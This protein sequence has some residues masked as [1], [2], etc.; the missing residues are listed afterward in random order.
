MMA[1]TQRQ[2]VKM[3]VYVIA[4]IEVLDP[5]L[6][7]EYRQKVPATIAAHGGR[8]VARGGPTEVLEGSWTPKRCVVLE[9][10]DMERFKTW[11]SSP[12]Y[13][14]LRALRQRASNSS[15]VVTQGL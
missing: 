6:F 11:W 5:V 2:G 7:E 13:A 8:Y 10:P 9:F 4:D 15:L 12:E 3:A 1:F 14:P